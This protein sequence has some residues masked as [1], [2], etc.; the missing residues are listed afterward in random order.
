ML[1]LGV[2]VC[3]ALQ[4]MPFSSDQG[5]FNTLMPAVIERVKNA[6]RA[7]LHCSSCVERRH[8]AMRGHQWRAR[9]DVA[10]VIWLCYLHYPM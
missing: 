9:V 5:L 10:C 1:L 3:G 8:K 2:A 4:V 7:F 6:V